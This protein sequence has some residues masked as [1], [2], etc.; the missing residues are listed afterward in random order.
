[1]LEQHLG[2]FLKRGLALPPQLLDRFR[3]LL[4]IVPFGVVVSQLFQTHRPL[5][6]LETALAPVES[7]ERIRKH[8]DPQ[9]ISEAAHV[10][11]AEYLVLQLH[12]VVGVEE[13]AVF[14]T[15]AE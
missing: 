6:I 2:Q 15:P 9:P 5:E 3:K 8:M 13:G 10:N 11:L 1:M 12:Q 4:S 14:E 7:S